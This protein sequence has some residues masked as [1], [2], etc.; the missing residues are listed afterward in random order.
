MQNIDLKK[1]GFFLFLFVLLSQLTYSQNF[2][3]QVAMA[4]SLFVQQNFTQA[5]QL[6]EKLFSQSGKASPAM[7]L[8]MAY[9]EEGAGNYTKALYYLSL[10][11]I[12]R[13]NL[14]VVNK[15]KDIAATYNL[16]GYEFKDVDFF[17][18]LYQRYYIYFALV[19]LA[20][21]FIWLASLVAR[22]VRREYLPA[23]HLIGCMLFLIVVCLFLNIKKAEKRAIISQD[24]VYLMNAPSAGAQLLYI[25]RKG[26]R[27]DV[28][29]K[30]DI[31]VQV[32]WNGKPAFVR[33]QNIL[34]V[35]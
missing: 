12:Q 8:K 20:I 25:A 32:L 29:G 9:I 14:Q 2:K 26:H 31:W 27:L 21:S 11:Y 24:N 17:M 7:L 30:Q 3:S 35:E 13:P 22:K 19:V 10:Y 6:Y 5:L 4:D 18:I 1:I 33:Q 23:R 28:K 34:M 15:M 16:Q